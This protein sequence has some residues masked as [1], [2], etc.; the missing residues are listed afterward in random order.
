V[1]SKS[2]AC[3]QHHSIAQRVARWLFTMNDYASAADFVMTHESIAAM[4]AVRRT[5]VTEAFP[6]L[7]A[8]SRRTA[9]ASR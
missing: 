5:D 1:I 2:V 7:K 3:G 8:C 4:L 9:A 6:S